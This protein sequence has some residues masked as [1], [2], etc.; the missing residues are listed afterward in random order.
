MAEIAKANNTVGAKRSNE[1]H[2]GVPM[3]RC[4]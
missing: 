2:P 4:P 3:A 1:R